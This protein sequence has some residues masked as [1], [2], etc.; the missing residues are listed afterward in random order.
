MCLQP[1]KAERDNFMARKHNI[2]A[3]AHGIRDKTRYLLG[4]QAASDVGVP[5]R[6]RSLIGDV[7]VSRFTT[8]ARVVAAGDNTRTSA[9]VDCRH[10]LLRHDGLECR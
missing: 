5:A 2:S 10:W 7:E 8:P 9:S 4:R 6:R 1:H 3:L